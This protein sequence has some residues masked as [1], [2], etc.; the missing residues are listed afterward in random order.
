MPHKEPIQEYIQRRRNQ[1]HIRGRLKQTLRLHEPLAALKDDKSRY[2]KQIDFEIGACELGG[3]VFGDH[4]GEEFGGVGPK[5]DEGQEEE[6]EEGDHALDLEADEVFV[7]GAVGLGAEGVEGGCE[8]LEGG[9][10]GD[11][12]SH[13]CDCVE[14]QYKMRPEAVYQFIRGTYEIP[15]LTQSSLC[16]PQQR[17]SPR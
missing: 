9:G 11:V 15:L 12:G 6:E 8:A 17:Y 4:E 3:A 1:Q 16:D 5:N 10:A 13:R 7:A 14:D 2:A